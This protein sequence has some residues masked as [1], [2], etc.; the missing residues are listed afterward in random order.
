M[1]DITVATGLTNAPRKARQ[2]KINLPTIKIGSN[3]WS[4]R[5]QLARELGVCESTIKRMNPVTVYIGGC[6]YVCREKVLH[7]IASTARRRNE[8][9][10]E[11][12]APRRQRQR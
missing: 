8:A 11:A 9:P 2:P 4:P 6:A 10:I 3:T 5:K 7:E 12:P 1:T